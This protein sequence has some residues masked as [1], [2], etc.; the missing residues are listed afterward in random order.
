ML[1][2]NRNTKKTDPIGSKSGGDNTSA[3]QN[4]MNSLTSKVDSR[5]FVENKKIIASYRSRMLE[6]EK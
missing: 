2:E 5:Q 3:Y 4:M 6:G 1:F